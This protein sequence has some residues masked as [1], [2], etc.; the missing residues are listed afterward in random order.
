MLCPVALQR[1]ERVRAEGHRAAESGCTAFPDEHHVGTENHDAPIGIVPAKK[2]SQEQL[3]KSIAATQKNVAG[4]EFAQGGHDLQQDCLL[5]EG[6]L[7]SAIAADRIS[8][9]ARRIGQIG[10]KTSFLSFCGLGRCSR[11]EKRLGLISTAQSGDVA[12]I[13]QLQSVVR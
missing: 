3:V 4:V 8:Y 11:V 7:I 9:L 2:I 5:S 13:V 6:C 1:K 12:R 10:G